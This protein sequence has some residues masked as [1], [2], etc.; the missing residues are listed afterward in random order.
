M[1]MINGFP[2]RNC[3]DVD[4]AKK[5]IDPV[6]PDDGPYGREAANVNAT[7]KDLEAVSFGGALSFLNGLSRDPAV[8]PGSALAATSQTSRRLDILA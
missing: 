2:C 6:R 3:A 4:M 5:H 8:A 7:R 1:E